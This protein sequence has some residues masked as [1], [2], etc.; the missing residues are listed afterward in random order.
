MALL[1]GPG[2]VKTPSMAFAMQPLRERDDETLA[3]YALRLKEYRASLRTGNPMD[4]PV[5]T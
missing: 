2:A 4:K 1:G 5:Y 3:D